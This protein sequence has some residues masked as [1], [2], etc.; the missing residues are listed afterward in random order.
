MIRKQLLSLVLS[1]GLISVYSQTEL[2]TVAE[3]SNFESTSR[4]EDVMTFVNQLKKISNYIKIETIAKT[5]EGRDIPL[6]I[7]GNPLPKSP[8]DLLNDKRVIV[9]IQ[10]NIHSGEVEGKEAVLMYLRDLLKNKNPEVLKDVVLLVCPNLNADGNDKISKQNRTNQNGPINGVGVRYNGQFLDLNRDAM[11]VE[12][13]EMKGVIENILNKWDPEVIMDCHTTN[14]S[15]HVEPVTFTWIMNPNCDRSLINYMRDRMM[16]DMSSTLLNKYKTENCFYGEFID[17]M[18]Y[19]KGWISYAA[20]PR[21]LSNYVGVRNRLGILNENYVYADYKSRVYGCYSLIQ[22]LMDYASSHKAEIKDLI[23]KVDAATIARGLNPLPADS[24]AIAYEGRPTPNN[25]FI[26]TYEADVVEA[27]NEWERYK[28]SDRRKDVNVIYIA[29]YFATKS[30]KSPFAYI[31]SIPAPEIINVL[32][33]HGI[34]VEKL[35]KA[36]KLEVDKFEI[37]DLKAAPRLNQG[38]YTETVEG[39]FVKEVK[40]F[41]IGTYIIRTSQKLGYLVSYLLEPQSDDG[42]LMWNYFDRYLVPQWS[43]NYY[44]YPVYKVIGSTEIKSTTE[45]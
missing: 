16:P 10:A 30:V 26:K 35:D 41:S 23:K 36:I 29:D 1:F 3:K 15:F 25:V 38:H 44:P 28:K 2:Q 22:S 34:V 17:M 18:D 32:K 4:Y 31:V 40:E 24:F 37:K 33:I 19:S 13:P 43:K 5:V 45:E 11:K 21:Y 27:D 14:G 42:L 20:E 39:A 8:K 6:L 12:S 9:Y 7:V